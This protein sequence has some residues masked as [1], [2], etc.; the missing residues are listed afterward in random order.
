MNSFNSN[1]VTIQKDITTKDVSTKNTT[2][3]PSTKQTPRASIQG[4]I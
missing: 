4:G 3:D 1:N 2:K